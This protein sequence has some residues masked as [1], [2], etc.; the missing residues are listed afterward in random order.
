MAT[1]KCTATVADVGTVM[2]TEGNTDLV[3][4]EMEVCSAMEAEEGPVTARETSAVTV[5]GLVMGVNVSANREGGAETVSV[6]GAALDKVQGNGAWSGLVAM[7]RR[8][9][10]TKGVANE[11]AD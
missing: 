2:V 5:W 3:T 7:S 11:H 8:N 6:M 4:M 1:E 9:V 10:T